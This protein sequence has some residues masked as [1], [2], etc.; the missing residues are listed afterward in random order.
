M[1]IQTQTQTIPATSSRTVIK[2]EQLYNKGRLALLWKNKALIDP[3]QYLKINSLYKNKKRGAIDG[4]YIVEY[5]LSNSEVGK[6]GYGR[7]YSAGAIGLECLE[8]DIRG[9]LCG[10]YYSDIDIVNCHPVLITQLSRSKFNTPMTNLEAY[11]KNRGYYFDLMRERCSLLEDQTKELVIRLLYNGAIQ[12]KIMTP[13]NDSI[14][15]PKEFIGIKNEIKIFIQQMIMC[16]EHDKLYQHLKDQRKTNRDGSFVSHIIQTEE[17]KCQTAMIDALEAAGYSVDVMSYDG[18]QVRNTNMPDSIL[19]DA[20]KAIKDATG[21]EVAL[22]VKPFDTLEGLEDKK[23]E[24]AYEVYKQMKVEWEKKHFYFKPSNTVVEET[25]EKGLRHYTWEH[26][27]DAF[28]DWLLP[29][30]NGSDEAFLF[31]REWR[32]DP[33]RRNVDTLVYKMPEDCAANEA[34]LFTGFAYKRITEQPTA[35]EAAD[36]VNTFNDILSAIC[37]DEAPVIEYVKRTFAHMLKK[38]F[39]RTGV[40]TAFASDIQGSGKDTIMLVIKRLI[41]NNHTAHYQSTDDYWDKHDTRQESAIFVYLEEACSGLNKAKANELKARITSDSISINP[42]GVK[43]YDVPN[44]G[45]QFMTTNETEPFKIEE[46][47]RRGMLI[48]PN[49]RCVN[50]N[51]TEIYGKLYT[52]KYLRAIGEHLEAIDITNWNSRK[53]PETEIK[54]QIRELSMTSEKQF[55][56]QWDTKGEWVSSDSMYT[57]YM[58]FCETARI[59]YTKNKMS[60]LKKIAIQKGQYYN[61]RELRS[62]V[63]EYQSIQRTAE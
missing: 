46:R 47:D 54:A 52:S 29:S 42:K 36:A 34:S 58:S 49:A 19:R 51:W 32:K 7:Y 57:D 9:F 40:I 38:P 25:A 26:S 20:E 17:R 59:P 31:V 37:N 11:V 53:F 60:L 28:N 45:R 41:G 1:P 48:A 55:L 44:I 43:A 30:K 56:E 63:R 35:E 14:D 10:E 21:Y 2:R 4:R 24:D 6:L 8:K 5:S 3:D 16:G 62:R 61:T 13:D 22:K 39:E 27:M 23:E 12:S 18:C 33:A 15:M 50:Y